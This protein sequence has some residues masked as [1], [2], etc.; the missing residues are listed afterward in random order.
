MIKNSTTH[1][2]CGSSS[3]RGERFARRV[4]WVFHYR[5]RIRLWYHYCESTTRF[6]LARLGWAQGSTALRF[7]ASDAT[8]FPT[9]AASSSRDRHNPPLSTPES[10]EPP[11]QRELDWYLPCQ[12]S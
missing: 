1:L 7:H 10:R 4:A 9:W 2:G 12:P 3:K 5:L 11:G 8:V 6:T